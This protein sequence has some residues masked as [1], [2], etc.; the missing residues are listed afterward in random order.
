MKKF[1]RKDVTVKEVKTCFK[2]FFKVN[3]YHINHALYSGGRTETFTREVFERGNAVVMLPYDPVLDRVV[4][5]EQFRPGAL[6]F[7]ES[8]W[9][10]ECVAGMFGENESP[11]EVA[12]REAEEE[13]GLII[14]PEY[15]EK[16]I[17][18]L[19]SPG[20][21]SEVIY[22]YLGKVNS[23]GAEGVFGLPEENEDI[24]V[25]TYS[26]AEAIDF[27]NSG[28]ITNAATIIALQWLFMNR[29]AIQEKWLVKE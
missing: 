1:F 12:I 21:T 10:L 15:V 13:A 24:L 6:N 16:I 29:A 8:P 23:E 26:L 17:E 27:V 25:Q 9:I 4:L 20:G 7:G 28:K 14:E 19:S 22:L 3:E 11:I 2:G 18:Y 5:Q